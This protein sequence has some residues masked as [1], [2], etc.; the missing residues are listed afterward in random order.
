MSGPQPPLKERLSDWL[1]RSGYPLEMKTA[2]LVRQ[3]GFN[4]FQSEYYFDRDIRE[5]RE[6]DVV[7]VLEAPSQGGTFRVTVAIECKRSPDKPWV[8]FSSDTRT[9][10]ADQVLERAGS[11]AAQSLLALVADRPNIQEL[12]V[13]K[14]PD[15]AGYGVVRAM[16]DGA[17]MPY[18]A[19]MKAAKAADSLAWEATGAEDK[20]VAEIVLPVVVIDG[21]LFECYLSVDGE[22][23]IGETG[24][25]SVH[26]RNP[27]AGK[28]HSDITVLTIAN[29]PDYL[30]DVSTTFEAL[31]MEFSNEFATILASQEKKRGT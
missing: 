13:F 8:V 17:D 22:P 20:V 4:A 7:G 11:K 23:V 2:S 6:I 25:Q 19:L 31:A 1:K 30:D 27:I 21:A 16:G 15:R 12:P 24:R 28:I 14:R 18:D 9:D 10:A 26:W 29:L 3:R 5:M